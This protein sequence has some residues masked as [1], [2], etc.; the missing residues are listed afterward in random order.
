MQQPI[1]NII[2]QTIINIQTIAII[3]DFPYP[4]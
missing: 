2:I 1:V 4:V 3:T